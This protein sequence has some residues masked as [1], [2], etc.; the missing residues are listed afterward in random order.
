MASPVCY[1]K[2]RKCGL[3]SP[4][5]DNLYL[6]V[7]DSNH[8][9]GYTNLCK[10]CKNRHGRNSPVTKETARKA[11]Y[12]FRYGISIEEYDD[13]YITQQGACAICFTHASELKYRLHIDHCHETGKV[14]GL[15][16]KRCN[17]AIGFLDED[18]DKLNSS[19]K[20]LETHNG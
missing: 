20:Y 4:D 5:S 12:K 17:L 11:Q 18:I 2:C 7:K 8:K 19:I 10:E 16:C 3:L 13:I 1:R 6:F 15:L 14:R 9:T